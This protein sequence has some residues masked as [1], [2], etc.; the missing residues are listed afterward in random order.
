MNA[1]QILQGPKAEK[2]GRR[3]C[4]QACSATI[5]PKSPLATSPHKLFRVSRQHS[6][7]ACSDEKRSAKKLIR[8]R[9]LITEVRIERHAERKVK[10]RFPVFPKRIHQ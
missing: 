6:S 8:N 2:Q 3:A 9:A 4:F 1:P 10:E 5:F 7:F